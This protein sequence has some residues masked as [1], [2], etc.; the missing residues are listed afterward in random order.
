MNDLEEKFNAFNETIEWNELDI[1]EQKGLF[2]LLEIS[3]PTPY[4]IFETV[5]AKG[6]EDNLVLVYKGTEPNSQ[7][8]LTP[9]MRSYFKRWLEEKYTQ[10]EDGWSYLNVKQQSEKED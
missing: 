8:F 10:G 4:G 1:N 6:S 9:A 3:V 2:D 7:L 5:Q